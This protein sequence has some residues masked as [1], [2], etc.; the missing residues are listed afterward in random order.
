MKSWN[1]AYPSE[2][3]NSDPRVV[4]IRADKA[5]GHG[6]RSFVDECWDAREIIVTLHAK[7]IDDP[8]AAVEWARDVERTY[9][10]LASRDPVTGELDP[11][12]PRVAALQAFEER[13]K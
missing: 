13:C 2:L 10:K 8:V 3:L 9:L 6:T 7:G 12:G 11:E 1:S 4:A 5:V